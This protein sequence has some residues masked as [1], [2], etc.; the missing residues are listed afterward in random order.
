MQEYVVKNGK[1][2]R[3]G[4][5]TGSCASAAAKAAVVALFTGNQLEE[6][7]VTTPKGKELTIPVSV[8]KVEAGSASFFVI[9]DSGD[10]PDIT[11]GAEIHC[12]AEETSVPGVVLLGGKGVGVVTKP[13]LSVEVG[14]A[15]INP[16]PR[17][18]IIR[19]ASE[20]LPVGK[21]VRI[22][23]SVPLGEKLAKKT[24]NPRLG[25]IGGISILGT[26]G[27]V[28]PMSEEAIK[29]TI[30]LEL[31]AKRFIGAE[32]AILVPGNY[33]E[34]FCKK[35]FGIESEDIVKISNY[36]GFALKSCQELGFKEVILAGHL[37]K[38][39]KVAA[40]IWNTHSNVSDTRM[41]VLTAY[42]ALMEM[43]IKYLRKVMDSVTTEEAIIIIKDADSS[44]TRGFGEAY[45]N[46][47]KTLANKAEERCRTYT[48]E[49]L[50]I[51]IVLFSMKELLAIGEIA[52]SMV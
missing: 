11:N 38:L 42:L 8:L 50:R 41:E 37:G 36:V 2:L 18:M 46:V 25:I 26:S 22:T 39:V 47:F 19:E 14:E 34:S 33:G 13:G 43:D 49:E 1:R 35:E 45:S 4:I 48:H 15:A 30:Y 40:G 20:V 24:Y 7:V 29:D 32:R 23:V 44:E 3:R 6:I 16:K 27:I 9:K 21:G 51:G 5:T 12:L 52:S 28:E 31:K 17:E 10:D